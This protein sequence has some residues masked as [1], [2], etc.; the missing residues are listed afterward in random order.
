MCIRDSPAMYLYLAAASAPPAPAPGGVSVTPNL[1][2][3][4]GGEALQKIV[5]WI[6]AVS[7]LG[8]LIALSAAG[9]TFGFAHRQGLTVAEPASKKAAGWALAG[10]LVIGAAAGLINFFVAAGSTI[11]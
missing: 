10:A 3:G 7:L 4:P 11:K 5:N 6:A 1:G 9:A 8:C 2:D